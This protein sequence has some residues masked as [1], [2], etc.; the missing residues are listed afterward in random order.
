VTTQ[1]WLRVPLQLP[2]QRRKRFLNPTE[3]HWEQ[4]AKPVNNFSAAIFYPAPPC[5]E[6]CVLAFFEQA[7]GSAER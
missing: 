2:C 5:G 1:V 7:A 3:N 6:L 4:R